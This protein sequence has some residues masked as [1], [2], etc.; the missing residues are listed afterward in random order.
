M[1]LWIIPGKPLPFFLHEVEVSKPRYDMHGDNLDE[2]GIKIGVFVRT[3][4]SG[5][6]LTCRRPMSDV[7]RHVSNTH[8][9][10][11]KT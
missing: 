5:K 7:V 11:P 8:N 9:K 6:G 4:L 10:E 2:G 1:N 3:T